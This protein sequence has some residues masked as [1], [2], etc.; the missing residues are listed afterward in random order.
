[1]K[2]RGYPHNCIL[3]SQ[4]F[5]IQDNRVTTKQAK[6]LLGLINSMAEITVT[7]DHRKSSVLIVGS[8]VILSS[9]VER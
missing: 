2:I 5:A 6:T 3:A 8:L 7:T 4:V 9:S 1:M